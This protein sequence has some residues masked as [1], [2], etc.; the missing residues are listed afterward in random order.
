M[1]N[2]I[3]T[4]TSIFVILLICNSC[5]SPS[6]EEVQVINSLNEEFSGYEF[7]ARNEVLGTHLEV[8]LLNNT[9]DSADLKL[10][11]DSSVLKYQNLKGLPWVY[12]SVH[13]R[14]DK[15]LFT[16]VKNQSDGEY[17]FFKQGQ[18]AGL[19]LFLFLGELLLRLGRKMV[20]Y[21]GHTNPA[22]LG[23]Q[24]YNGRP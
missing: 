16:I 1:K 23:K 8:Q 9:I 2:K 19:G 5:G 6:K 14:N 13:D 10:L 17:A 3:K 21:T 4:S 22:H 15:Y 12:L 18:V 24:S 7:K 20:D 11:Y